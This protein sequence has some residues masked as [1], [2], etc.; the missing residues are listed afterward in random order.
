[1]HICQTAMSLPS[2]FYNITVKRLKT[3]LESECIA[4]R[5]FEA[6]KN[7]SKS[8]VAPISVQG[9]QKMQKHRSII[10]K[11]QHIQICYT[12]MLQTFSL[13][14]TSTEIWLYHLIESFV[15]ASN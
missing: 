7:Y 13:Q 1:M 2:H 8:K 11:N 3:L 6:T 9:V 12:F 10:G 5:A 14:E 15:N 4:L